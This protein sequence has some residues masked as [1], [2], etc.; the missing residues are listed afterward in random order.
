MMIGKLKSSFGAVN[1]KKAIYKII[2]RFRH[3]QPE[4]L[5]WNE[6]E[7]QSRFQQKQFEANRKRIPFKAQQNK[8]GKNRNGACN[9]HKKK[10]HVYNLFKYSKSC[11]FSSSEIRFLPV[12]AE[13]NKL[14]EPWKVSSTTQDAQS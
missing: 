5:Y 1:G 4:L 8:A 11:S 2:K 6:K 13:T 12:K 10:Y 7:K 14:S 9:R 3:K